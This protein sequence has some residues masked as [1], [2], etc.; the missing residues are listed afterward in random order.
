MF[1]V[2]SISLDDFN[3]NAKVEH[4]SLFKSQVVFEREKSLRS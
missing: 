1:I 4:V 2:V 3:I